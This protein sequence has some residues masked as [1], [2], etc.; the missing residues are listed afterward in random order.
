VNKKVSLKINGQ[1]IPLNA[2][3]TNVIANVVKAMVDSL[4]KIPGDKKKIELL[5]EEEKK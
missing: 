2:F 4:D 1:D 3:V 5:I